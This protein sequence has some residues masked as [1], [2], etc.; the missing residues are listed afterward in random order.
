ML[1][2]TICHKERHLFLNKVLGTHGPYF[3]VMVKQMYPLIVGS[4]N[5]LMH[6]TAVLFDIKP[7]HW[8]ALKSEH[9]YSTIMLTTKQGW[10][11]MVD[12]QEW[13]S[14]QMHQYDLGSTVVTNGAL[15]ITIWGNKVISL[16]ITLTSI[17][18]IDWPWRVNTTIVQLCWLLNRDGWGWLINRN[19]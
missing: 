4:Q 3:L 13:L 19:D 1:Y 10:L 8:L 7:Q 15:A 2:S 17:L 12:Q 6:T 11:R 18:K 9:N 5:C 16:V 14:T